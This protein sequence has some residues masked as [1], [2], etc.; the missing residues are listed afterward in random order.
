MAYRIIRQAS[1]LFSM[2]LIV[3]MAVTGCE[4]AKPDETPRLIMEQPDETVVT[5]GQ[6]EP[7]GPS[8]PSAPR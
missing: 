3:V 8:G 4:T 7:S 6:S 1:V 2:G 5:P